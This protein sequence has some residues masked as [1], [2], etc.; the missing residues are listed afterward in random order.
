MPI[1]NKVK[2]IYRAVRNYVFP[3]RQSN[4][5]S[6]SSIYD[7]TFLDDDGKKIDFSNY[8]GK[9]LLIVNTASACGFTGQYSEM[10]QM[11]FFIFF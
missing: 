11:P 2:N 4:G 1:G 9:K 8:K 7:F 10:Q 6:V 5:K 3:I